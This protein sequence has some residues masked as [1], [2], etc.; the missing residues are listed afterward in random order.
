MKFRKIEL[1][2]IN[3]NIVGKWIKDSN[4]YIAV[5]VK[6]YYEH[7]CE[8]TYLVSW[9]HNEEYLNYGYYTDVDM[10]LRDFD[11]ECGLETKE[12]EE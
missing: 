8:P 9:E 4:K 3:K 11:I 6:K 1:K 10:L 7:C 2:D 5:K 12:V